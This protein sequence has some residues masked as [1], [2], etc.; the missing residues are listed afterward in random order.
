MTGLRS[1]QL[2]LK[3]LYQESTT[4]P[5]T[6]LTNRRG[7]QRQLD[8]WKVSHLPF[9]VLALDVDHFKAIND[10]FGHQTGDQVLKHLAGLMDKACRE[11]D[12][13]C[14]TGGEEFLILLP[15]CPLTRA[16]EVAER[17]RQTI[18]ETPNPTGNPVTISIGIAHHPTQGQTADETIS[19]ADKALYLAKQRGRNRV[20]TA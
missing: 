5:L 8:A 11:N 2:Q 6:G 10:R 7:A 12:L 14:R 15:N 17:L 19:L 1:L 16:R 4:D 13:T 3:F 18:E 20:E 9:A